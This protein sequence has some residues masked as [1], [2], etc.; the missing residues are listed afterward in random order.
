MSDPQNTTEEEFNEWF[1]D[2]SRKWVDSRIHEQVRIH[3]LEQQLA[4]AQLERDTARAELDIVEEDLRK[5]S[6]LLA[7][8]QAELRESAQTNLLLMH[9]EALLRERVKELE[10]EREEIAFEIGVIWKN[11]TGD[12]YPE[13][14]LHA[15]RLKIHKEAK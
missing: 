5:E 14:A 3:E 7:A 13:T 4:E 9:N 11:C 6:E 12:T 1:D 10:K 15:L 2:C 8:A